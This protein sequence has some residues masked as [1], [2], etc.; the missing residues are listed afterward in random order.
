M[1]LPGAQALLGFQF[2]TVF[3]QSY[4][5]LPSS[6]KYV[7]LASLSATALLAAGVSG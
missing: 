4:D 5:R 6:V 3:M 2:I 7:H 1:V